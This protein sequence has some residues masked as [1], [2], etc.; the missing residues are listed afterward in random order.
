[1]V[2]RGIF[3]E[4][5]AG[6]A[7][8]NGGAY[9]Y[10]AHL[11]P[12]GVREQFPGMVGR[13]ADCG[14]DLAGERVEVIP[15]AHFMMGGVL[16]DERCFTSL[17]G[18]FVAG[19]DTGGVHGANRLGGNGVAD[20]T[21]FGG[22]AGDSMAAWVDQTAAFVQPDQAAIRAAVQRCERPFQ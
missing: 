16:V 2:S 1:I 14:F 4:I 6:R 10:M 9:I 15:T 11:G 5:A 7:T 20:S 8:P 12:D 18:L 22:I 21:V 17:P 19:E 3:S 13:C